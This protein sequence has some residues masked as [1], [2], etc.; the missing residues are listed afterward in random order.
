VRALVVAAISEGVRRLED[1]TLDGRA[2]LAENLGGDERRIVANAR[3]VGFN[4]SARLGN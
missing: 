2:R 3:H 1:Q 4:E